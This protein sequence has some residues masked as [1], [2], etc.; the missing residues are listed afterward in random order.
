MVEVRAMKEKIETPAQAAVQAPD[1]ESARLKKLVA[2]LV[3]KNQALRF[4]VAALKKTGTGAEAAARFVLL[5]P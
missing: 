1:D 2:E 4:E 5:V 3:E